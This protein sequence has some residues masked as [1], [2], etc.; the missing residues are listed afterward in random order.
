MPLASAFK[1]PSSNSTRPLKSHFLAVVVPPR[2][3]GELDKR[4]QRN[5]MAM[6]SGG[7]P[8]VPLHA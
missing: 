3:L 6:Q 7:L 2:R 8:D 4:K 5:G 1:L